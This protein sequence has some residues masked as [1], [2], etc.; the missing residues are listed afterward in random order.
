MTFTARTG[1][2]EA[3]GGVSAMIKKQ[4]ARVG[5]KNDPLFVAHFQTITKT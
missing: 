3:V 4:R 1:R 5:V 2:K